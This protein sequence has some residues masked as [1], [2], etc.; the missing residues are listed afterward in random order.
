MK[1][2]YRVSF[3]KK[4]TDSTGHPVDACQGTVEVRA[5]TQDCAIDLARHRFAALKDVG[6]WSLRADYE[7]AELLAARSRASTR[8][9]RH[10][11]DELATSP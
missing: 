4:L 10:R 5:P 3:F 9:W 1:Q 7:T 8:A 6:S 2:I 11:H